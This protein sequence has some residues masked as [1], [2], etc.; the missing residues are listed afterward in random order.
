VVSGKKRAVY[1]YPGVADDVF[2]QT[3]YKCGFHRNY[4]KQSAI[5][6]PVRADYTRPVVHNGTIAVADKLVADAG[7]RDRCSESLGSKR[8]IYISD[9]GEPDR[10]QIPILFVCG[11]NDYADSHDGRWRGY[12][13][14]AA[15]TAA[16][17]AKELLITLAA[18]PV[19]D[20]EYY[21]LFKRILVGSVGCGSCT[22]AS[23]AN[24]GRVATLR[25]RQALFPYEV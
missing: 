3:E 15:A 25:M 12:A 21:L 9:A 14:A 6:Q 18:L 17:Y 1:A 19:D 11:V 22:W 2:V 7:V 13:A 4:N 8:I 10:T 16:A 24:K 23:I 5:S 20:K